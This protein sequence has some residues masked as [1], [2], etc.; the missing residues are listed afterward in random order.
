LSALAPAH[1]RGLFSDWE[2]AAGALS[3]SD[4]SF[5]PPQIT[6]CRRPL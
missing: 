5:R 1:C 6:A 4:P 3:S 2:E